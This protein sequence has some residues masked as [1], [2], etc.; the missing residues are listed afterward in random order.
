VP[1]R[2]TRRPHFGTT[3]R[4][5]RSRGRTIDSTH[6]R[7]GFTF[8]LFSDLTGGERERVFEIAVAQLNL[9]RP[10]LI[11]NVGDLIEGDSD[12]T[13]GVAAEWHS[14]DERA[15]RV[16]APLFYVGG[17]HDLAS[18]ML[19][20]VWDER[21]GRRYYHFRYKDV[22][23]L[24]LDTEDNSPERM[25]EI[26]EAREEALRIVAA[27]GPEAAGATEYSRMPEQTAG[28]IGSEQSEYF[29]RVL[30]ENPDVRWTFLFMHKAPWEREDE[31]NFAAIEQALIARPYTVFHGHVHAYEYLER[32]GR[33]YIQL[34][35]TGGFQFADRGRA[36]DHVTLVTVSDQGVDI[37]NLLMEGILDKTGHVPLGGDDVCF[38]MAVCGEGG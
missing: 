22:L 27:Q 36:A 38:E 9:L 12:D 10:E 3:S 37:A 25:Q 34:A 32:H 8:A 35:T 13:A 28:N 4:A 15:D 18:P 29:L 6:R 17:N 24:V 14:F 21:Y 30:E 1:R 19:K 5:T 20:A 16:R 26:M 7:Y 31:P 11:M 2:L 33:D 23:F